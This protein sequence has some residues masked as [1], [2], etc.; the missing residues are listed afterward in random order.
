MAHFLYSLFGFNSMEVPESQRNH[1][2]PEYVGIEL[3]L[4]GIYSDPPTI[5]GWLPH[6]DGSL[7]NGIEYT[8]SRP[9]CGSEIETV[10]DHFYR[11]QFAYT[12]GPRTSTHIHVNMNDTTDDHLRAMFVLMYFIEE[13]IYNLVEA[14]RKWAGYSVALTEMDM[15]RIRGILNPQ[16]STR[17]FTTAVMPAR[18]SERYYG[19]NVGVRRHGTVEFRYFPGGPSREELESWLDLVVGIKRATADLSVQWFVDNINGP[20]DIAWFLNQRLG[21]WGRRLMEV[22]PAEHMYQQLQDVLPLSSDHDIRGSYQRVLFLTPLY[23][24]MLKKHTLRNYDKAFST[25]E[26]YIKAAQVHTHA[27]WNEYLERAISDIPSKLHPVIAPATSR[28]RG[29]LAPFGESIPPE[30]IDEDVSDYAE[31]SEVGYESGD[32]VTLSRSPNFNDPITWTPNFPH[33]TATQTTTS[34]NAVEDN[35]FM[36]ILSDPDQSRIMSSR[37]SVERTYR[38]WLEA[39]RAEELRRARAA[40]AAVLDDPIRPAPS[41]ASNPNEERVSNAPRRNR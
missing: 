13:G 29:R 21:E 26:P 12:K 5:P 15:N 23:M 11:T 10:L 35:L 20:E 14:G 34:P 38:E 4:E 16:M 32:E 40:F 19:F 6:Q 39:Q 2:W 1:R 9:V 33:T 8:T 22:H 27:E 18:N 36:E 3:E 31:E 17:Q 7:R 24:A 41:P 30:D 37:E 25:L 28:L